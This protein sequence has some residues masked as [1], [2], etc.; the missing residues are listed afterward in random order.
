VWKL[1]V[2]PGSPTEDRSR[3]SLTLYSYMTVRVTPP[4]PVTTVKWWTK[5]GLYFLTSFAKCNGLDTGE[6]TG[7]N[8]LDTGELTGGNELDTDGAH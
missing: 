1:C 4:K 7:G 6:L 5:T 8:E 3:G 2:T